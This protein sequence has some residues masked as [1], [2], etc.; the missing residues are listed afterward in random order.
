MTTVGIGWGICCWDIGEVGWDIGEIVWDMGEIA[1]D[2]DEIEWDI[3]CEIAEIAGGV[4]VP[5]D[6]P[7]PWTALRWAVMLSFLLNFLWQTLHG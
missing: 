4:A 7:H 3:G 2:M 1:W 6:P 5:L